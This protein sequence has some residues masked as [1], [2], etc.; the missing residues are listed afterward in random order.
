VS[1][2]A[3]GDGIAWGG[4]RVFVTGHTGFKGAWLV[5][6]LARQG[7][8]VTGYALPPP[9]TPSLFEAA[10][11]AG[12]L[13]R[14]VTGDVRDA[15]HLAAELAAARPEA[16]F[17]LAAQA[18]VRRGHRE[19][20]ET[21]A[22]NVTGTAALLEAVRRA[23]IPCAVIVVTSDKCYEPHDDGRPHREEDALGGRDPY[24]AS[25]AC[26]ELVAAAARRSSFP[27]ER[28]VD[29]G[30]Q[31]ATVRAGNVVGGGDWAE[32][33]LV[34]D[35]VAARTA[36]RPVELRH[37]DAIR[38]WQHVLDPLSG[39]LDLAARMLRD[40]AAGYGRAWNFGP[41]PGGDL[42][43]AAF[44]E[45]FFAAAGGGSW[46]SAAD[47]RAPVETGVLRLAVDRAVADLGWR[48]RFA[49][50]VAIARTAAWYR[51]FSADPSAARRLCD[52][53]FRAH[54]EASA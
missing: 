36:G 18:L 45:A 3:A 1:G 51:G 53:D 54:E 50:T 9:T 4:R 46:I 14:H 24:S 39:Y 22:T 7:A 47:P 32:D 43:V 6:A 48:P 29:H 16:V 5:Q 26:A 34:T 21:F 42:T 35:L 31:V 40:P 41:L 17:H 23:A 49:P 28:L 19:P 25:K 52:D 30:V 44:V 2:M 15:E 37:P 8:E 20:V 12:L 38:P 33:R 27:P 11:V 10:G 13:R